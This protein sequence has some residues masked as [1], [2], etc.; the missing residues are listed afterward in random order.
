MVCSWR[1][2]NQRALPS[3]LSAARQIKSSSELC[4]LG[5][6]T[7]QNASESVCE[8]IFTSFESNLAIHKKGGGRGKEGGKE[9]NSNERRRNDMI[10]DTKKEGSDGG[11]KQGRTGKRPMKERG[12]P[13]FLPHPSLFLASSLH[14]QYL[15][16]SQRQLIRQ[17]PIASNKLPE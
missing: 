13:S 9:G 4:K 1:A 16:L 2:L 8:S 7:I 5:C 6:K 3:R 15:P 10:M 11:V 12:L 14:S 17:E